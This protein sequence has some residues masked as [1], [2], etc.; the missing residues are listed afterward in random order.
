MAQQLCAALTGQPRSTS[1]RLLRVQ[2]AATVETS[3][4]S[5]SC[6]STVRSCHPDIRVL[7]T[8][9]TFKSTTVSRDY[10][11]KTVALDNTESPTCHCAGRTSRHH[12]L[13]WGER[14]M[15]TDCYYFI[16]DSQKIMIMY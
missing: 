10:K 8:I 3:N 12:Q 11:L 15:G 1:D 14:E 7:K 6:S 13:R 9:V 16:Q 4:S 2:R 5:T